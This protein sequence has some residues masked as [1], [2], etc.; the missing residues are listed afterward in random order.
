MKKY[1][2]AFFTFIGY[3]TFLFVMGA[4]IVIYIGHRKSQAAE[5]AAI[6]SYDG[7]VVPMY[8]EKIADTATKPEQI[9]PEYTPISRTTVS[10]S[11]TKHVRPRPAKTISNKPA[12]TKT[13]VPDSYSLSTYKKASSIAAAR[14]S[15]ASAKKKTN[16]PTKKTTASTHAALGLPAQ[17]VLRYQV[18]DLSNPRTGGRGISV[19]HTSELEKQ[20]IR[21]INDLKELEKAA[22]QIRNPSPTWES[23]LI[24]LVDSN[25]K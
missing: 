6:A 7:Q 2:T 1:I 10:A 15:T 3:V 11:K 23:G 5:A 18:T 16:I 22:S 8:P 25:H 14:K 19:Y 12:R 21:K 4:G 17:S 24:K 20:A 13:V 9:L